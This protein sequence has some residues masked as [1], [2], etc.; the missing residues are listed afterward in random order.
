[1]SNNKEDGDEIFT[2]EQPLKILKNPPLIPA[3]YGLLFNQAMAQEISE[4]VD[5]PL[6]KKLKKVYALQAKTRTARQT[7]NSAQN[8]EWLNY[9]KG[10]AAAADIF[11]KDM[12]MV[13]E[14]YLKANSDGDRKVEKKFKK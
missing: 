14:E 8:I 6:F 5:Q 1:M 13:R 7:L 11:F 4:W 3:G 2:P 10:I 12:E 9:Y